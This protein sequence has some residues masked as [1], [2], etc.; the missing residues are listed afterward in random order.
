[1]L[2]AC[3]A[4][5]LLATCMGCETRTAPPGERAPETAPSSAESVAAPPVPKP[6]KYK[7]LKYGGGVSLPPLPPSEKQNA[8]S[9]LTTAREF[10]DLARGPEP[11][12]AC[13][14]LSHEKP[15]DAWGTKL[16]VVCPYKGGTVYVAS[17][18]PDRVFGTDDDIGFGKPLPWLDQP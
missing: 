2:R 11:G 5:C 7:G 17:A 12:I 9:T 16:H 8:D 6:P 10:A 14:A 15:T 13:L 1:M 4:I 3:F 18:G